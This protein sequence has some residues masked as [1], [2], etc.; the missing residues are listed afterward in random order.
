MTP[1]PMPDPP[2]DAPTIDNWMKSPTTMQSV[3]KPTDVSETL[4][5]CHYRS[6]RILELLAKA[7]QC[8]G[9]N[10]ETARPDPPK[11]YDTNVFDQIDK[12]F[13]D[14]GTAINLASNIVSTV[15]YSYDPTAMR[16]TKISKGDLP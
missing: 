8:L 1:L 9:T 14:L 7:S 5:A 2:E 6:E 15:G 10:M 13:D 3:I 16:N 12:L 4:V 11:S